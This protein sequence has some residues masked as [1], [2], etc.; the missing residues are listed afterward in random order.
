MDRDEARQEIRRNWKRLFPA[1]RKGKGIICPLCGS[2]S[3]KNGTGITEDPKRPGQLTCWN[4]GCGFKGDAID[5][6]RQRDGVDYIT[7]IKTAAAE[8]GITIAPR[9]M[10]AASAAADFDIH[11]LT[12]EDNSWM[13]DTPKPPA[14]TAQKAPQGDT[15]NIPNETPAQAANAP[16]NGTQQGTAASVANYSAYYKQCGERLSD[17]AAISYLQARGISPETAAA[18]HLGYD[19]AWIS[20]AVIRNQ[21]EKGSDWRPAPTAR[22]IV[23]V[24]K[25]HYVARAISPDV[26][27][28][29]KMNETG[30]GSL[31]IFNA[32]AIGKPGVAFLTEGVFDALS[33]IECG[34][35]AV[36]LN[37][38]N[39]AGTLIKWLDRYRENVKARFVICLDNDDAGSRAAEKL[40][41]AFDRLGIVYVTANISGSFKDPNEALT[42]DR[43]AFEKALQAAQKDAEN[44]PEASNQLP[45]LLTFETAVNVFKTADDRT[46]ELKSFPLFSKTAKIKTH[47]SVV[48]AADTGAG[49]SSLAINFLNDLNEDYPCIYINLEMDEITVLR[50]LTAI[51]SGIELDRIEGYKNDEKTEEAVNIAL[52]AITSRKPLQVIQGQ[53]KDGET[54]KSAY[55]LQQIQNII[56][57][58]TRDRDETTI[59]IIDHSLLV[60]TQGDSGN[61]YERFTEVSE[62]LRKMALKYNIVLFVLLQQNRAGKASEDERPRNSSLKESGS[63]ENDAAQICFLWYDPAD[64][65]KKLLLTKNRHGGCGEFT[66]NYWKKTQT[67]TEAATQGEPAAGDVIQRKPTKRERA[68]QRLEAAYNEA[69]IQTFGEPTI[70]AMAEA[71]DVTTATIKSWIKEYGGCFVG[72]KRVDPAGID[73]AVEYDGFIKLTPA[74]GDAFEDAGQPAGNGQKVPAR[75]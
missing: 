74:D 70:R 23:P 50:R 20:P 21:Q 68:R 36:A 48:I 5:L 27:E 6:I 69:Y 71:A 18:Y 37:S 25:N 16:E 29:S 8:L 32:A 58:S 55:L 47:D 2:G 73:T 39:N 59:V 24:N 42:G 65:K 3:G 60:Q 43:A 30:G 52:R 54:E 51:Y 14:H 33:I 22:I 19:P 17:P 35:A 62:R 7:A 12:L 28:Y 53:Y 31:G 44:K 15:Q 56:E 45:G 72:G 40:K 46:I 41:A 49:K 9:R 34:G 63:W 11:N 26:K 75:I 10:T 38:T 57:R 4:G 66:L 13:N 1:D 64:R 61:R 67:Y